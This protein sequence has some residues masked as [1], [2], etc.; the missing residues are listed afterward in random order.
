MRVNN[1]TRGSGQKNSIVA[2]T[3]SKKKGSPPKEELPKDKCFLTNVT[4]A[5]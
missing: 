4:R 1:I 2:I 5:G 3:V